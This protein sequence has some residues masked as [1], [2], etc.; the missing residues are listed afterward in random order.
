MPYFDDPATEEE[1]SRLKR[2]LRPPPEDLEGVVAVGRGRGAT[3]GGAVREMAARETVSV[4]ELRW[5][6]C[7]ELTRDALTFG[8]RST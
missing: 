5:R 6:L 2:D 4:S 7:S 1:R 3:G 8:Y